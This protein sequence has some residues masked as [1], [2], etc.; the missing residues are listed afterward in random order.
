V[1]A[2]VLAAGWGTRLNSKGCNKALLSIGCRTALD[3]VTSSVNVP[4]VTSVHILHNAAWAGDFRRW[5]ASLRGSDNERVPYIHL[6]SNGVRRVRDSVGAVTD[7]V[8]LLDHLNQDEP[9]VLAPADTVTTFNVSGLLRDAGDDP[10][11]TVHMPWVGESM[12]ELGKVD[13]QDD[14]P[15]LPRVLNF[16]ERGECAV[17]HCWLG[18]AYFPAGLRPLVKRYVGDCATR[19]VPADRL[20]ELISWL[21]VHYRF[22]PGDTCVR[23]WEPGEGQAFDV[24]S[25]ASLERARVLLKRE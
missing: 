16:Y 7:L 6:H 9:F 4:G 12:S 21:V 15:K 5:K 2:I 13:L 17:K 24:G 10:V 3:W 14:V 20:G 22:S 11:I 1:R 18:P 23:A 8:E 19:E 25:P